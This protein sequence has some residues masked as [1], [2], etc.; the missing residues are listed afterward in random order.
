MSDKKSESDQVAAGL[1]LVSDPYQIA[2]LLTQSKESLGDHVDARIRYTALDMTDQGRYLH[3]IK[4]LCVHG[5][6]EDFVKERKWSW[7]YVHCC[8]KLTQVAAWLPQILN[9][10]A[11]RT[12]N[13]LLH[14]SKPDLRALLEGLTPEEIRNLTPWGMR[15]LHRKIPKTPKVRKQIDIT[16]PPENNDEQWV[17]VKDDWAKAVLAMETLAGSCRKVKNWQSV[18]VDEALEKKMVVK[19]GD[20]WDEIVKFLHPYEE[21]RLR[22]MVED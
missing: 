22:G 3:A 16:L 8:M 20:P 14:L 7:E 5:E 17:K 10:P 18:Y 15:L 9:V 6:W 11:G 12:I 4:K 13:Q 2:D 19:L 21:L 1:A